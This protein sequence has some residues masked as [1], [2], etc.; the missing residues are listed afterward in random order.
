MKPV[1]FCH[2]SD[3]GVTDGFDASDSELVYSGVLSAAI[4][5]F[6]Q[7]DNGFYW[8]GPSLMIKALVASDGSREITREVNKTG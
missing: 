2:C 1:R 5:V 7:T 8:R 3:N 4:A 6:P